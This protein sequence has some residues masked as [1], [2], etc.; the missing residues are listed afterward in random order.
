MTG[1][2]RIAILLGAIS[3]A[4]LA[5]GPGFAV[6]EISS[7][8]KAEYISDAEFFGRRLA[9]YW[10]GVFPVYELYRADKIPE[11]KAA[12]LEYYRKRKMP[13]FYF[14]LPRDH[15]KVISKKVLPQQTEWD[16]LAEAEGPRDRSRA[17]RTAWAG[18]SG[19]GA[20]TDRVRRDERP[21]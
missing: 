6:E 10:P 3:L 15:E 12:F 7:G 16:R 20:D 14:A 5:G 4:G 9:R 11:A 2:K 17:G 13:L 21:G 19:D 8:K 1:T 18:R